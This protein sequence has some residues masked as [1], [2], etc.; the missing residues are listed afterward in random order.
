MNSSIRIKS[1]ATGNIINV[2]TN[3]PDYG[4]IQVEQDRIIVD[5]HSGFARMKTVHALI[6]GLVTDLKKFGWNK[7][8]ELVGTI[9]IKESLTP[10]NAKDPERDYKLA[11]ATKVVCCVEGQPIYRKTIFS[12]NPEELDSPIQHTNGE[13]IKTAYAAIKAGAVAEV[14]ESEQKEGLET[15]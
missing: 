2:S 1:D 3:N 14:E 5:G 10:F 8:T 13:D 15:V 6:P 12:P 11:G 9:V 7:S 4:H